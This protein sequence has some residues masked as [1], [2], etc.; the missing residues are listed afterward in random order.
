[1]TV[2]SSSPGAM[3]VVPLDSRQVRIARLLLEQQDTTSLEQ[4]ASAL[5]LT[6]RVVRYNLGSVEAYLTGRGLQLVR[7]RGVGIWIVGDS[8]TRAAAVAALA[9]DAGPAVLDAEE[10][11][12]R[13]LLALLDSAPDALRSEDLESR[14]GVSRPTIRRDVRGAEAWLEQ[15]R[16]HLRRHPGVGIAVRGSEVEV[17]AAL[18][19]LILE[20]LPASTVDALAHDH[21]TESAARHGLEGYV[22]SLDLPAHR[23]VISAELRNSDEHETTLLTATLSVGIL[24]ARVKANRHARLVRGRLRSLLDHPVAESARR[25]AAAI[26]ESSGV[27]LGLAEA[28]SITES[29]LGFVEL[30]NIDNSD[31]E[32][33]LVRVVDR[34]LA[35]AADRI[36]PALG[37]DQLLRTNL[38]E[39]FRRLEVRLRYG[40]PVSNPLHR[41]VQK[42]YPD[43]YRVAQKLVA[44]LGRFGGVTIPVEETG[45]LTMYLAGSLERHQLRAKVRVTVVC[46]AGMATAWILVSRLLAEFPQVEVG[47]V[48]SKA[49]FEDELADTASEVVISTVPLEGY[50]GTVPLIVVSPL[51][52]E[53]DV[54]RLTKLVGLP[55]HTRARH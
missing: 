45:F 41:D 6:D 39:H 44:N 37:D 47:K 33:E 35:V 10:R 21:R 3:A 53:R 16:L 7:R 22:G 46:P 19:A 17:R 52:N 36:H 5:R 24:I 54:R 31:V 42:R 38:V 43:V 30:R 15:H 1:M 40:L 20:H 50:E 25:I 49:A 26:S 8:D 48:I 29:L 18:L 2:V 34:L 11:Q 9:Q 27:E 13:V 32:S 23:R 12:A 55:S 28:A 51:L 4:V 14:L